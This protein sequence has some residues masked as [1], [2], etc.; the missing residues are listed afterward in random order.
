MTTE[1]PSSKEIRDLIM[2]VV[3]RDVDF[4]IEGEALTPNN[5]YGGIIVGEYFNDVLGSL[6]LIA[7]D[8]PLAA[9]VGAALALIPPGGAEADHRFRGAGSD[10]PLCRAADAVWPAGRGAALRVPA[11]VVLQVAARSGPQGASD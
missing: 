9:Y 4:T 3:G 2:G 1:L 5:C 10:E 6:A 7:M 8:L 11:A